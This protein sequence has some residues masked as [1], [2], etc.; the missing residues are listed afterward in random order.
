MCNIL[1]V[2]RYGAIAFI[3]ALYDGTVRQVGDVLVAVDGVGVRGMQYKKVQGAALGGPSTSVYLLVR[4][5]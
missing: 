1:H 3:M 2:S 4:P 5:R